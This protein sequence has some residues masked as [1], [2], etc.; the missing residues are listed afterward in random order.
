MSALLGHGGD[1]RLDRPGR[2][3][4]PRERA[5]ILI[6]PSPA[7]PSRRDRRAAIPPKSTPVWG[8]DETARAEDSSHG[9]DSAEQILTRPTHL[10]SSRNRFPCRSHCPHAPTIPSSPA[11]SRSST[12]RAWVMRSPNDSEQD[13]AKQDRSTN[14]PTRTQNSPV[15][16]PHPPDHQCRWHRR[17]SIPP[18]TDRPGPRRSTAPRTVGDDLSASPVSLR[19]LASF[20]S[21]AASTLIS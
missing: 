13:S 1:V 3:P 9:W 15:H 12:V 21:L 18:H 16:P 4:T 20:R 8:T 5:R 17:P 19:S 10:R 14:S 6:P 11:E 7:P 2:C